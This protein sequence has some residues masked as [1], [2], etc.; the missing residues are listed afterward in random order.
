MRVTDR[1]EEFIVNDPVIWILFLAAWW[2]LQC[3]S[4]PV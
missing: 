2:V 1:E 4:F 3:L